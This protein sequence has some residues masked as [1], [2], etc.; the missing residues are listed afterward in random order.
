M[1]NNGFIIQL[2][3]NAYVSSQC[4]TMDLLS[5]WTQMHVKSMQCSFT[6]LKAKCNLNSTQ[7]YFNGKFLK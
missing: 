6:K 7:G 1:P 3:W 4:P 5:N 2:N